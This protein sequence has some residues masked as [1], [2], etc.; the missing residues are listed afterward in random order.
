MNKI[1]LLAI[2]SCFW[3][4]S[5]AQTSE[6]GVTAIDAR[7]WSPA[8]SPFAIAGTSHLFKGKLLSPT[9][10]K[11]QSGDVVNFPELWKFNETEPA[12]TG[13]ATYFISVLLPKLQDQ[14]IGLAIPQMYC[15]YRLWANG[16][17]IAENG[18]VGMTAEE[19]QPMWMPQ[20]IYLDHVTDS[21]E[22]VLQIANFHHSKGGIK[23]PLYLGSNSQMKLKRGLAIASN[24]AE[25][26]ALLLLGSFFLY[27][28][29]KRVP[30]KVALYFALL[31][32]TWSLRSLFSNLYL[33][34]SFFPGFNWSLM[35]RIEYITLYLTMM[36]AILFV[37]ELF[38]YEANIFAKYAFVLCNFLFTLFTIFA[39]TKVF[40]LWLNLYLSAS[41]ALLL[42]I[43]FTVIRAWVNERVGSGLITISIILGLN[44][45]AYD[46]FVYE[47]FSSY[48]PV[49]FAVGYITIFALIA[50]AL[51]MQLNL[52]KS[53]TAQKTSLTY[54]DLY[55]KE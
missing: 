10:C 6:A 8:D 17:M 11:T 18:K 55:K 32:L 7:E 20:T 15:S 30:K 50:W 21:L 54:D 49:I 14:T 38:D 5:Q 16:K 13:V 4:T 1:F 42:Y 46:I 51:S 39:P 41:A 34:I 3:L 12:Q 48:D 47:G 29:L 19:T 44:I 33:P 37:S 31:C 43:G 36:W 22:L 9:E 24:L 40:T 52:V 45:F 53:K 2:L 26:L 35:V 28:F 25:F 23:E 27:I